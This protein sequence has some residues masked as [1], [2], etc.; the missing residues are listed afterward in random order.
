MKFATFP[1]LAITNAI[2]A[3]AFEPS[4]DQIVL[5]PNAIQKVI[6]PNGNIGKCLTASANV[7]GASVVIEDCAINNPAQ[8]WT[9]QSNS[10][11]IFGNKCLDDTDGITTNGQKMQIW[12]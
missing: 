12:T 3:A 4:A 7:N 5:R 9:V 11:Q 1:L 8:L 2:M 6:H 10:L